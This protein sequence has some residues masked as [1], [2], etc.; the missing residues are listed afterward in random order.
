[1]TLLNQMSSSTAL[2]AAIRRDAGKPVPSVHTDSVYVVF[3]TLEET[4]AA[5]RAAASFASPLGVP[6][7]LLHFQIVP[8]PQPI[9]AVAG[10]SPIA[11]DAFGATLERNGVEVRR[12][13]YACREFDA[14]IRSVLPTP[15]LV[16][17]GVRGRRW[18]LPPREQLRR[19]LEAAGHFVVTV[20]R[21]TVEENVDA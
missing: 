6:V 3:T 11:T 16:I 18:P 10:V 7:T 21:T 20:A 8:Y 15:S 17:V 14:A 5:L 1:M 19:R 4:H 9:D 12:R 13:V 2:P